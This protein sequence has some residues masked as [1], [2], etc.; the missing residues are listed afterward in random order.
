MIQRIQTLMN[1]QQTIYFKPHSIPL[2]HCPY[3]KSSEL[4]L[5]SFDDDDDDVIIFIN[6]KYATSNLYDARRGRVDT[7]LIVANKKLV[8]YKAAIYL[9]GAAKRKKRKEIE[10][11]QHAANEVQA[12]TI[13]DEYAAEKSSIRDFIGQ[14]D[15]ILKS[16]RCLSKKNIDILEPIFDQLEIYFKLLSPIASKKQDIND[17]LIDIEKMQNVICSRCGLGAQ[18]VTAENNLKQLKVE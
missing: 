1:R 2:I 3:L 5:R 13:I 14:A 9:S 10:L 12:N 17:I 6:L 15:V 8:I 4:H 16:E 11:D 7:K 18:W